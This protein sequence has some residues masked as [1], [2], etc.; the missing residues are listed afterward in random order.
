MGRFTV[1]YFSKHGN[2]NDMTVLSRSELSVEASFEYVC[3]ILARDGGIGA[4]GL[5]GEGD[6]PAVCQER[7][8]CAEKECLEPCG[9]AT[10]R[11]IHGKIYMWQDQ[12]LLESGLDGRTAFCQTHGRMPSESMLAFGDLDNIGSHFLQED[13][14]AWMQGHGECPARPTLL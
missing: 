3:M 1:R 10:Y 11:R 12:Y 13:A 2:L 7:V 9:R 8:Q 4:V 6:S 14:Y 5:V